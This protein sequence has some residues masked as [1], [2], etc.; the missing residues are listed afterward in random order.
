MIDKNNKNNLLLIFIAIALFLTIVILSIL[1]LKKT[2]PPSSS[3]SSSS[4]SQPPPPPSDRFQGELVCLPPDKTP[5]CVYGLFFEEN[6]YHLDGLSQTILVDAD[7]RL[8]D[9]VTVLGR[10]NQDTI[11]VSSISAN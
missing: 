11:K 9:Q 1:N 6:Y 4:T 2:I 8:G 5:P 7:F 10:V 3:S